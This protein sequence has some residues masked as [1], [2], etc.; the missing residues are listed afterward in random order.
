MPFRRTVPALISLLLVL[1]FAASLVPMG[2]A[3]A[4][5]PE[6]EWEKDARAQVE[7]AETLFSKRQYDQAA[8]TDEAF[9]IRYPKS[10]YADRAL[11]L[12]G[13][14]RLTRRDYGQALS[15]YKELIE[16]YPAS[17]LIPEAKYKLGLCYFELKEY[18]L[19]V[20]NLEDRGRIVDPVKLQRIAEMLSVAYVIRKNYPLAVKEYAYLAEHAQNEKQ[21]AGYR[22]R[23]LELVDKYLTEDEL[24]T[25]SAGA[26][27]PS[28]EALLRLAALLIEQRQY[29]DAVSIS[30]EFLKRF[31]SH[32]E[33]TRGEMLLSEATS[34]L[35][36]PRY[37]IGAL[38]PQTGQLAFF[39]DR[40]LKGIQLAVHEYNLQEPDNRVELV[41][42][43]TEGSPEKAV[44]ALG[45]LKA[46]GVVA[47]IGPITTK[48][49]EA[50]IPSLDKA[51]GPGDP[52]C[53]FPRGIFREERLDIQER[54]HHRQPG[55]R[56]SP[57]RARSQAQEVRYFLP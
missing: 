35:T 52:A 49:E 13:E 26:A 41:V 9:L 56:N 44:A 3:P 18:D 4:L 42:K 11:A 14:I 50:I 24:R 7:Q 55:S 37:T 47:V 17:S 6:P 15:Y 53:G 32:P 48:E 33:K 34:G 22:D 57:V 28:D 16:K 10:R 30:T 54:A 25:L 1:A 8:K 31:P 36:A 46:K 39:G 43:D 51:P 45:E 12:M 38:L 5:P 19:A 20:A 21:R 27:F 2:C 23:V 40:V 29:R